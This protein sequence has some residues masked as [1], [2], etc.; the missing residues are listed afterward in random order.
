[1]DY[2]YSILIGLELNFSDKTLDFECFMGNKALGKQKKMFE[3]CVNVHCGMFYCTLHRAETIDLNTAMM[4]LY[5]LWLS[6]LQVGDKHNVC[7]FAPVI[8]GL[9]T[10]F[11]RAILVD[12]SFNRI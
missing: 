8:H 7:V 5:L 10:L 2:R 12:Q 6:Q 4:K 11:T 1:M 9:Q 3:T